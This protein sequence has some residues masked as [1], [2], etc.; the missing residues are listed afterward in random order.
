MKDE[1]KAEQRLTNETAELR[2]RIAESEAETGGQRVENAT[3]WSRM[4]LPTAGMFVLLCIC[5][6]SGGM[7][8]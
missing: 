6:R 3:Q 2:Q 4:W 5:N 8:G 1:H 7:K